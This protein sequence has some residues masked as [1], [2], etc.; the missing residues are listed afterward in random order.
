MDVNV[1]MEK[2]R[3][4]IKEMRTGSMFTLRKLFE[5][6]DWT[7]LSAGERR[8]FGKVFKKEVDQNHVEGVPASDYKTSSNAIEY[9][10]EE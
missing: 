10:K 9:T 8:K 7:K 4:M 3:Q 6:T 2:A 5:G 1:W